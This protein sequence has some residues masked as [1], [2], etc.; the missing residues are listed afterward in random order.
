MK[1]RALHS[2]INAFKKKHNHCSFCQKPLVRVYIIYQAH[3]L[4]KEAIYA[5]TERIDIHAWGNYQ[6]D[7]TALCR[8]CCEIKTLH[9]TYLFDILGF[10]Q[11]LLKQTK[12]KPSSIQEYILRLQRFDKFLSQSN[13]IISLAPQAVISQYIKEPATLRGYQTTLHEYE[14]YQYW[15]TGKSQK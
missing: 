15:R 7:L 2:Y 4:T 3:V 14:R 10:Y 13:F 5:L 1:K 8:F 11:Y 12:L 9:P 6:T